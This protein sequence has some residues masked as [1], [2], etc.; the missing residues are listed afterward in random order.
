LSIK[1]IVL[2]VLLLGSF[3]KIYAQ[4]I[5]RGPYLQHRTSSLIHIKFK[6][7]SPWICTVKYGT[8]PDSLV[9]SKTTALNTDHTAIL[10]SLKPNTKYY[11][12]I[13]QQS[14][15]LKG[16]NSHFFYTSQLENSTQKMRIWVTG[17]CGTGTAEQVKVLNAFDNYL[18]P[19]YIDAW[20][21]LGDNAYSNGTDPEYQSYFFMPYQNSRFMAQTAIYP[22]LGNHDY[23]SSASDQNRP[24]FS[25]F[26]VPINGEAGGIPSNKKAYY[27]YNIGN[28]HFVALDSYGKE[29]L[30]LCTFSDTNSIQTIWLKADLAANT[31]K[32]TIV[33]FH[34]P[35]YT[36]GSHNSD[37]EADLVK[38]RQNLSPIFERFN[39]DLVLSGH[40]HTY[41]RSK[42]M[43]GHTGFENSYTDSLHTT[44][45]S[46]GFYDGSFNSC[47]YLKKTDNSIKGT[48]YA[49]AGSA[50]WT[51]WGQISFPHT[52][53]PYGNKTN[54]GSLYLEI[55]D[56]RL[57]AKMITDSGKIS[58]KFTMVKDFNTKRNLLVSANKT[59]FTLKSPY[60][61]STY[62]NNNL[63]GSTLTVNVVDSLQTYYINDFRNCF[64]D[65]LVLNRVPNC[66]NQYQMPSLANI[67]N[68]QEF[69]AR[70][71][72]T[73]STLVPQYT[74]YDLKAGHSIEL[75]PG[76]ETRLQTV[77][78]AKI[79]ECANP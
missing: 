17:D 39:V 34:H 60:L 10:D 16:S 71:N 67:S 70:I 11:Y 47:A 62:W 31:K 50:G 30:T 51:P 49:V 64:S 55:E 72:M 73:G 25:I 36:M 21:L 20:L 27:S 76:F 4:T 68:T 35:P 2:L 28:T 3:F 19:K 1:K 5:V 8:H 42:L 78:S 6:T 43:K 33:Y 46:S 56:N 59:T 52:A 32:W 24:Y 57:D 58:D 14:L 7:D 63:G 23:G 26:N 22:A 37:T 18:G 74:N 53:M 12:A 79:A 77:F 65:T 66:P 9:K 41:E 13:Y 38:I 44:Q 54:P 15:L 75:L 69:K 48:V 61:D 40:S 29:P 45:N